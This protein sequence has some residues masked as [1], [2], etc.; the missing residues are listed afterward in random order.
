MTIIIGCLDVLGYCES[1]NMLTRRKYS[2][3]MHV[4]NGDLDFPKI[5][6]VTI[7]LFNVQMKNP[8]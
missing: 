8:L 2:H 3:N 1:T 7:F 6:F 4:S 5:L